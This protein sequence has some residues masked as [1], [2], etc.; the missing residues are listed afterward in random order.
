MENIK[1]QNKKRTTPQNSALYSWLD[2]VADDMNNK[3]ESLQTVLD[4]KTYPCMLTKDNLK[5]EVIHDIIWA[6]Y[7]SYF[8]SREK[9][10]TT[11]LSTTELQKVVQ[12]AMAFFAKFGVEQPFAYE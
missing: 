6:M 10:T 1:Q 11:K 3:G 2:R 8:D 5:S 9:V 4:K 12:V 7:S